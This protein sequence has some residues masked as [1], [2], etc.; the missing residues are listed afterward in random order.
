MSASVL[1]AL[2]GTDEALPLEVELRAGPLSMTLRG[3]HIVDLKVA[4]HEVWHGVTFLYR[5]PDWCTPEPVFQRTL[6]QAEGQGFSLRLEGVIPTQPAIDLLLMP[7]GDSYGTVKLQARAMPRGDILANR[8]G[9]CLMHPMHAMGRVLEVEH[10][11]GRIS[12]S[13]FP[14]QVPPWPPF[15]GVRGIRH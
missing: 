12:R 7:Q 13:T 2:Y 8:I 3:G 9:L 14:E 11:D 15:T 5:D 4:G 10:V 1:T 6:H